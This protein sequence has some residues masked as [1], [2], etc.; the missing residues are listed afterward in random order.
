[1][2]TRFR[3]SPH[4]LHD[5]REPRNPL[6]SPTLVAVPH[7]VHERHA[8]RRVRTNAIKVVVGT[9]SEHFQTITLQDRPFEMVPAFLL[10]II[11]LPASLGVARSSARPE[12]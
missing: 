12:D 10:Q 9:L 8:G 2:A 11:Q 6:V 3:G 7:M 1:M 4:F 5:L